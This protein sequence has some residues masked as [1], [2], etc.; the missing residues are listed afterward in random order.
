M[1]AIVTGGTGFIGSHLIEALLARGDDVVCVGRPG[2]GRARG[3]L[4]QLPVGYADVGVHDAGRLARHLEGAD[5]VFHL[6]GRNHA[7]SAAELYSLNT[8]GT[9]CV[10]RAAALHGAAAPHVLFA[11]SIAAAG[12]C[13]DGGSLSP[14]STPAPVSCYGR[15]KILAEAI[16]H[17]FADRVPTTI[18]RLPSVYGPRDR[19]LFKLF[20]LIQRGVALTI[21]SWDREVSLIHVS[22]LVQGLLVA[23]R[24]R[25]EPSG[26][27]YYL[28]HPEPV[29]WRAFARAAGAAL[30]RDPLLVS[31]PGWLARAVALAFETVAALR[32]TSSSVNRERM[33]EIAQ[34]RWVCDPSRA[35]TELAFTPRITIAQGI[36]ETVAWYR[37][38]GWL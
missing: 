22:D 33:L 19:G 28:A 11:S 7:R 8:D 12:P 4:A 10:V 5:V 38:A 24:R 13:R 2:G 25:A 23:S 17:A 27:I 30:G 21:G 20:R 31:V 9:A 1:R 37:E 6:A 35:I 29:T 15:S 34:Q 36:P 3:W 32:H 16:L 18:V 26:R 14:D